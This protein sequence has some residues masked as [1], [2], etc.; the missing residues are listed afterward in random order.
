MKIGKL[1]I[2]GF[3]GIGE[4]TVRLD[5]GGLIMV[6]GINNDSTTADSNGAGKSTVFDSLLWNMYGVTRHGSSADKIVNRFTDTGCRTIS[7]IE[8]RGS[9]IVIERTRK[10]GPKKESILNVSIDGVDHTKGTTKDTQAMLDVLFGMN[11]A[12][13][14][15]AMFFG[16]G[17]VKSFASLTDGELKL[18]FEQALGLTWFSDSRAKVGGYMHGIKERV[19]SA[20]SRY[21]LLESHK[22]LI[23][24]KVDSAE[25]ALEVAKSA[26]ST[27]SQ[28]IGD[29]LKVA[30]KKHDDMVYQNEVATKRSAEVE[31]ILSE[32][33]SKSSEFSCLH[34][35]L[36]DAIAQTSSVVYKADAEINSLKDSIIAL[37]ERMKAM[38][39][40]SGQ[41]CTECYQRVS[42]E[43]VSKV[44]AVIG[45]QAA[46]IS[47]KC[48]K[49]YTE[50][51]EIKG[52]KKT[53]SS[54]LASLEVS[55]RE[56]GS[57]I[58]KLAAEKVQCDTVKNSSYFQITTLKSEIDKLEEVLKTGVEEANEEVAKAKDKLA[59][60]QSELLLHEK[61]M[62]EAQVEA[63]K[64]VARL[65]K[66]KL[67]HDA[68]GN[69]GVK[70]YIFDSI[71]P[72]IN[73]HANKYIQILDP[74]MSVSISTVTKLASGDFRDKFSIDVN[75]ENG[76][77]TLSGFSGGERQ[78]VNLSVALA[79]NRVMRSM[80]KGEVPL[81]VLDEPFES[82]DAG[83]SDTV[84]EL[85][86]HIEADNLYLITHNQNVKDL[87][88]GR[89][90]VE[91]K[92][93]VATVR[94]YC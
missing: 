81:M 82:L 46:D 4:A 88:P 13:F 77:D 45:S 69:G 59:M 57:E 71:T 19:N 15:K 47:G 54:L 70:S 63:E 38:D 92:G 32:K 8:L 61:S 56:L 73:E 3:L 11:H 6:E 33:N 66:V 48:E 42:P 2:T 51:L 37:Q 21:E 20:A 34:K 43:L 26:A 23:A 40:K 50:Y 86:G 91:K 65:H 39:H 5:H 28:K 68:L 22:S 87:V 79:F 7:E 83:S 85:L 17:D 49:K 53:Q 55:V 75:N 10:F 41:V 25:K 64:D 74:A 76:A 18:V 78:K 93:R 16:Q 31:T 90:V 62:D 35:Q 52:R 14:Q 84:M 27:W 24:N 89:M 80:S 67:L 44:K 12:V 30:T 58:S 29:D 1:Q 9:N 94:E 60:L 36:S 72:E